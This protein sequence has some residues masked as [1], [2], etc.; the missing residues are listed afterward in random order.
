MKKSVQVVE[1]KGPTKSISWRLKRKSA[2][3]GESDLG[4][5]DGELQE[6]WRRGI[7]TVERGA[8]RV[9]ESCG[10]TWGVM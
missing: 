8:V 7:E 2:G 5:S 9:G 6:G 1:K 10:R 3:N 4:F